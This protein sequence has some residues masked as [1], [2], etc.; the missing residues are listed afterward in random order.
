MKHEV[1]DAASVK[2]AEL[3]GGHAEVVNVVRQKMSAGRKEKRKP[4]R[5]DEH[6]SIEEQQR[7]AIAEQHL[8]QTSIVVSHVKISNDA[9]EPLQTIR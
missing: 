3:L 9:L 4:T 7:S 8:E 6:Q 2:L 1:N 5:E